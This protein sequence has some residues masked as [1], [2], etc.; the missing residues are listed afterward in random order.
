MTVNLPPIPV[1]RHKTNL[2]PELEAEIARAQQQRATLR[3]EYV[4][5]SKATRRAVHELEMASFDLH[6]A[7]NR[8]KL[9]NSHLEMA[10][11]GVLGIDYV[12]TDSPLTL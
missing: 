4:Q 12:S 8:R 9:A 11:A 3:A 7:E 1:Y 6:A 5:I 2:P 10:R